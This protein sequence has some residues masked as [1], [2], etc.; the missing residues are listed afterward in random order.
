MK[1]HILFLSLFAV[2]GFASCTY[3][4][5]DGNGYIQYVIYKPD[6]TPTD[7]VECRFKSDGYSNAYHVCKAKNRS[8]LS[9]NSMTLCTVY[10]REIIVKDFQ[11]NS[12]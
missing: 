8:T 5:A 9:V 10:D 7:S 1:K 3:K 2:L 11:I 12:K 6:G 4:Q